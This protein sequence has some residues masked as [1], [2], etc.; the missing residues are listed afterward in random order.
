[1][2]VPE[3]P[4]ILDELRRL[5]EAESKS[6]DLP[7]LMACAD[8]LAEVGTDILGGIAPR[9]LPTPAARS[10]NG[11]SGRGRSGWAWSGTT[12]PSTRSGR[13][14]GSRSGSTATRRSGRGPST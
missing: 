1:M 14:S 11:G 4:R 3:V 6:G 9:S 10:C 13:S 8:V 7:A 5:V 12:T 2:P